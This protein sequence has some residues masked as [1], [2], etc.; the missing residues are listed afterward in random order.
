MKAARKNKVRLHPEL[1]SSRYKSYLFAIAVRKLPEDAVEDILQET[2]L[3]ALRSAP[4]FRGE[5]TE[6]SWLTSILNHKIMDYYRKAYSRQGMVMHNAIRV[7][8]HPRWHEWENPSNK[9]DN[10]EI[11]ESFNATELYKV[12]HSGLSQLGSREQEVLQLKMRGYS[13]EAICSALDIEKVNT[14]VAL[15]RARKKMKTY[16]NN[17]W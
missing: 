3:A 17:N 8:E 4:G 16:L 7:S 12:F 15:S 2:Y 1:W 14:W 9:P 6:R 13:T 5:S 10:A 11:T